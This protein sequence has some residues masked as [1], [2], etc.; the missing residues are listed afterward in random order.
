MYIDIAKEFNTTPTS[1]DKNL[2]TVINRIWK[3]SDKCKDAI[4]EI[5]GEKFLYAK[6]S[7]KEFLQMIYEYV[8]NKEKILNED[9][10]CPF[11]NVKCCMVK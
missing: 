3:N 1:V 2:R 10:I 4:F 9:R 8:K 11:Y 6:P 7:N 5:F